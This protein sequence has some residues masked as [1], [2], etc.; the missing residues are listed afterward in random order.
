MA[1]KIFRDPL[2]NYISIERERDRWL[3]DLLECP[4]VQRL[5]R[6]HQLGITYLTYP[7]ADHGRF[8][9]SLGVVHLMQEALAHLAATVPDVRIDE[10][11]QP[12]LAAALIHDVG[13]GPFSHLFEPCL[14]IDHEDWSCRI[15][16]SPESELHRALRR[17]NAELPDRVAAL[18]DAADTREPLW[19]KHL[20]S[21]QLD[22]D[23]LDYLRRDSL[24]TGAGFGH[25]DWFR[26]LH[27]F[28]LHGKT[29]AERDLVWLEKA[30]VAI[31][32]YIFA[33]FYMYQNVYLH[34]TTR[35]YEKILYAMWD[36]ARALRANG[37]DI[38]LLDPIAD[39][40]N[41]KNPSVSQFLRLEEFV[42]LTQIQTWIEHPDRALSDLARRFLNRKGFTAIDAPAV[43]IGEWET[44]LRALAT[45]HGYTPAHLYVLRDDFKGIAQ[46]MYLPKKNGSECQAIRLLV[47]GDDEPVEISEMLPRLQAVTSEPVRPVRYY[48]PK[49]IHS[50]AQS[51]LHGWTRRSS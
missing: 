5:R 43:D 6:V 4:E 40:W 41:A 49:E 11:R 9:H 21:S 18:V 13:H 51:L 1:A 42:V 22:V 25:F 48:V 19:Q 33:R 23:R 50:E 37:T 36:H 44:A 34:K 20:L 10:V 24:F 27:S 3:L 26:L 14:G 7:G 2:Y 16:L 45:S 31:E 46:T 28:T 8:S 12:L 15:I 38:H 32:E 30:A 47:N 35:C 39:F 29:E 17:I